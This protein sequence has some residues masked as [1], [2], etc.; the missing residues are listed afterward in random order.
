[1]LNPM[2][3]KH[4]ILTLVKGLNQVGDVDLGDD[5]RSLVYVTNGGVQRTF[6]GFTA[7]VHDPQGSP[8]SGA[9][10]VIEKETDSLIITYYTYQP[11]IH[12]GIL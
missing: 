3:R 9:K 12:S 8:M 5:G 4:R 6:F 7:F 1:M 11:E 2:D 10:A